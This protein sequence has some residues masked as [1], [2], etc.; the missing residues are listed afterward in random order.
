MVLN[1]ALMKLFRTRSLQLANLLIKQE[2]EAETRRAEAVLTRLITLS[3]QSKQHEGGLSSEEEL[4]RNDPQVS[5]VLCQSLVAS[6]EAYK[7]KKAVE[8]LKYSRDRVLGAKVGTKNTLQRDLLSCAVSRQLAEAQLCVAWSA[9]P[10]GKKGILA[11]VEH[12][13]IEGMRL[14]VERWWNDLQGKEGLEVLKSR[15]LLLPVS[16]ELLLHFKLAARYGHACQT[17][18]EK[19]AEQISKKVDMVAEISNTM[20]AS[21]NKQIKDLANS[22]RNL[23]RDFCEEQCS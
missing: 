13:D 23:L 6:G 2:G 16:L 22:I 11:E 1:D 12:L 8:L 20:P 17:L 7:C 19:K 4:I 10:E 21:S 9:S 15:R 14:T 5:N 18:D 3:L